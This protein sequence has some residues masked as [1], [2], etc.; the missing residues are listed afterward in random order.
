M[1]EQFLDAPD[2]DPGI[3]QVSRERMAQRMC[4]DFFVQLR[5]RY[6]TRELTSDQFRM[7]MMSAPQACLRVDGQC[8]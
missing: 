4:G 7:L 8:K 1:S 5:A 3:E 6:C 2:I